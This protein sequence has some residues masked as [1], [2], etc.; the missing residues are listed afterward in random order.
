MHLPAVPDQHDRSALVLVDRTHEP[1]HLVGVEVM[2][3]Q[4]VIQS[5]SPC[6]RSDRQGADGA[7]AIMAIPR[8]SDRG[9]PDGRPG[10]A[11]QR[12]Q[13][14]PT[15]I[16]KSQASLSFGPL[17]L[18]GA[19]LPGA[20]SRWRPRPFYRRG[21]PFYAHSSRDGG[22]SYRR[23]PRGNRPQTNARLASAPED[24][25]I[26]PWGSPRTLRRDPRPASSAAVDSHRAWP[27]VLHA[28]SAR[29]LSRRPRRSHRATAAPTIGS[30]QRQQP[31]P[32][33]TSHAKEAGLRSV[34][35]L[36]TL[37][38]YREVS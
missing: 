18:A 37:R 12:L 24:N 29:A 17:F 8:V 25:S 19:I 20:I 1:H 4:V 10:I 11:P 31:L 38:D 13:Q 21:T 22:A 36:P 23:S 6:P 27:A 35:E 14:K 26:P 30:R 3:D 16:E 9:Q 7:G 28:T 32:S 34:D 2:V 33:A 5:D 15:F